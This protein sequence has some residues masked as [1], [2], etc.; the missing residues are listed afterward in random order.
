M[1]IKVRD[2]Y[3]ATIGLGLGIAGLNA[4]GAE[5]SLMNQVG[6]FSQISR[7]L[8]RIPMEHIRSKRS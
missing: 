5:A 8:E 6:S 1:K 7:F 2:P 4:G 3:R